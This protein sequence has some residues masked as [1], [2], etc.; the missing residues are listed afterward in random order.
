MQN[1]FKETA[2]NIRIIRDL[3]ETEELEEE[4]YELITFKEESGFIS[5]LIK[6]LEEIA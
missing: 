1:I 4:K 2:Q 6:D 5:D 3:V